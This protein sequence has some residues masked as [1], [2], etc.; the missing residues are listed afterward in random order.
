MARGATLLLR[1]WGHANETRTKLRY[2]WH[3]FF[4]RF[5]VL[6][7]PVAATAARTELNTGRP[8]WVEPP[9]PGVTPP[10]RRVP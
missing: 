5:D 10:S 3:E 1:A 8:R 9:L 7:T 4:K 2:T 6:L